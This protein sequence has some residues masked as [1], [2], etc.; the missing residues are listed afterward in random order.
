M[1]SDTQY[2]DDDDSKNPEGPGF[3]YDENEFSNL[4]RESA[5]SEE[6]AESSDS[7]VSD[8]LPTAAAE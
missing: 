3:A 7:D 2:S 1:D 6:D 8:P 4:D 5:I